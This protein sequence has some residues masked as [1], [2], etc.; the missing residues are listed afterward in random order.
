M[1]CDQPTTD[2]EPKGGVLREQVF[3]CD[4]SRYGFGI[5]QILKLKG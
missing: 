3:V 5:P 4:K 2:A 1:F